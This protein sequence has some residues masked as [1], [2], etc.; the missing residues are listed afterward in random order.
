MQE[1]PYPIN[2]IPITY[3]IINEIEK[4]LNNQKKTIKLEFFLNLP[5][6]KINEINSENTTNNKNP[7]N[8]NYITHLL[9]NK[10]ISKIE[11]IYNTKIN[12]SIL[13]ETDKESNYLL[14]VEIIFN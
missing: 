2:I 6:E 10:I 5:P 8:D 11:K 1:F 14:K 7:I 3:T 9:K 13:K 12:I 4:N